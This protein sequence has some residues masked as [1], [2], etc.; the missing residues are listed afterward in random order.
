MAVAYP[1]EHA[2]SDAIDAI[3]DPGFSR[4]L[5]DYTSAQP[6]NS[7]WHSTTR[8]PIAATEIAP[9]GD[10][11]VSMEFTGSYTDLSGT[12]SPPG[13][14]VDVFIRVDQVLIGVEVSLDRMSTDELQAVLQQ[15]VDRAE[16][17]IAGAPIPPR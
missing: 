3:S 8:E 16:A 7:S 9:L 10:K 4:C 14:I 13:P 5:A 2:A 12:T 6:G 11:S 17:V 15:F 1:D